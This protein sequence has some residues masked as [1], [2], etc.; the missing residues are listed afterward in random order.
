MHSHECC[1]LD[2]IYVHGGDDDAQVARRIDGSGLVAEEA[3]ELCSCN[4]VLQLLHIVVAD[5]VG[6]FLVAGVGQLV[7]GGVRRV[8][9]LHQLDEIW[10]ATRAHKS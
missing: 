10:Q 8:A 1:Q 3:D 4:G 6:K 9:I 5:E 7:G 2:F